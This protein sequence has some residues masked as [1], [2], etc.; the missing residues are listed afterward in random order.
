MLYPLSYEGLSSGQCKLRRKLSPS[1]E[2]SRLGL[3]CRRPGGAAPIRPP[4]NSPK[5]SRRFAGCGP[6]GAARRLACR[7]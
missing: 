3:Y 6:P 5:V 1:G 7:R 2:G 4:V